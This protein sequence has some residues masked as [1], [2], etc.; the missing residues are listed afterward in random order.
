[1]EKLC[2]DWMYPWTGSRMG[3]FVR[4]SSQSAR[5]YFNSMFLMLGG[6]LHKT[7]NFDFHLLPFIL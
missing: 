7:L 5:L 1:M 2:F 4:A 6:L 3:V